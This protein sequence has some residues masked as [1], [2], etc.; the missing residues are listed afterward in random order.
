MAVNV[1]DEL[2]KTRTIKTINTS[3]T[4]KD[5]IYVLQSMPL[6][7][8]NSADAN[9][10]N[11]YVLSGVIEY[12]K[13]SAQTWTAGQLVY[14][15]RANNRFTTVAGGN[16]YAGL[17]YESAPNPSSTGQ[18]LLMPHKD[19]ISNLVRKVTA[20][21]IVTVG[22]ETLSAAQLMTRLILRDPAGGARTDTT[23]T[24]AQIVAAVPNPAVGVTIEIVIRNTAD[25]A[26]A[27]TVAGGTGVTVSGTATIAQNN[28]KIFWLVL[29][30]VTSGTEAATLYSIGTL[31]H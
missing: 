31:V 20:T 6:L 30:N 26:E 29:D 17:V 23:A 14:F 21:A 4:T 16:Y 28:S 19:D 5:L 10:S 9:V 22:N 3:A 12:A 8:V 7:A 11:I 13:L 15:D 25:A 2:V 18:V 1:R 24:A 27:I